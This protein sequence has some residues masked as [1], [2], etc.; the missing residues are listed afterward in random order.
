MCNLHKGNYCIKLNLT[1]YLYMTRESTELENRIS[2]GLNASVN[3]Y[4]T[5]VKREKGR[6]PK[7]TPSGLKTKLLGQQSN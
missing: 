6:F 3:I 4:S 2:S 7:N 1:F 5:T